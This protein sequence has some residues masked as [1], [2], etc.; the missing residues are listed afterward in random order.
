MPLS[1][2]EI[3]RLKIAQAIAA[4]PRLLVMTPAC[5]LLRLHRRRRILEQ[6]R[7]MPDTTLIVFT[8][9]RDLD[10]FDR[11]MLLNDGHTSMHT[12]VDELTQAEAALR[13]E[14]AP[15]KG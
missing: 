3:L 6:L 4:G 15:E 14:R 1:N 7:L 8:N 12:T 13:L 5:D 2:S 10:H 9:R 11:Y